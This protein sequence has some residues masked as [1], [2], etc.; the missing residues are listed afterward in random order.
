MKELLNFVFAQVVTVALGGLLCWLAVVS[1]SYYGIILI[2]LG[3]CFIIRSVWRCL[4][5][6]YGGTVGCTRFVVKLDEQT[7]SWFEMPSPGRQLRLLLFLPKG[8]EYYTGTVCVYCDP[9]QRNAGT[10]PQLIAHQHISPAVTVL[11][12]AKWVK[13]LVGENRLRIAPRGLGLN[14]EPIC[15]PVASTF[16]PVKR[17][18]IEFTIQHALSHPSLDTPRSLEVFALVKGKHQSEAQTVRS[19]MTP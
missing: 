11:G 13:R 9:P 4:E 10:S 3:I 1:R 18:C 14:F 17:L 8:A 7:R 16:D 15:I 5:V 2:V 19:P 6:F 12:P